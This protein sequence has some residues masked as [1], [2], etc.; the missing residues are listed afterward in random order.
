MVANVRTQEQITL[1]EE[2]LFLY[3]SDLPVNLDQYFSSHKTATETV[4]GIQDQIKLV[5]GLQNIFRNKNY[6]KPGK[7]ESELERITGDPDVAK[8]AMGQLAN[9]PTPV[10]R[11][12]FGLDKSITDAGVKQAFQYWVSGSSIVLDLNGDPAIDEKATQIAKA[13]NTQKE[14]RIFGEEHDPNMVEM[15]E[16]HAI[17][18]GRSVTPVSPT[19]DKPI[20]KSIVFN[21]QGFDAIVQALD[22]GFIL[23]NM[24]FGFF[25]PPIKTDFV[26]AAKQ[27]VGKV[28]SRKSKVQ[29][30]DETAVSES[31]VIALAKILPA[32]DAD[33]L[34]FRAWNG[35]EEGP[36][37]AVI[38][39]MADNGHVRI[40]DISGSKVSENTGKALGDMLAKNKG[41][42]KVVVD[43]CAFDVLAF[44]P[45]HA[46][47]EKNPNI[48]KFDITQ[49][50]S[51][52]AGSKEFG[53]IQ[54]MRT[55]KIKSDAAIETW[56]TKIERVLYP[57][58]SDANAAILKSAE[59]L[60]ETGSDVEPEGPAVSNILFQAESNLAQVRKNNLKIVR[61][62][63]SPAS[64]VSSLSGSSSMSASTASMSSVGT[65]SSPIS[66]ATT[67]S[68]LS[69]PS[70]P[71]RSRMVRAPSRESPPVSPAG[72]P[73][74]ARK[75]VV[76]PPQVVAPVP[77]GVD[78][79]APK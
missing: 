5:T 25:N 73:S 7:L 43:D 23:R 71:V 17:E 27:L 10:K 45:I 36:L 72:S 15:I 76:A 57:R 18:A 70:S 59:V 24:D 4:L 41:L 9:L 19:E 34:S 39:G 2:A 61:A 20:E 79:P 37:N 32:L 49:A 74:V 28:F 53:S 42:L 35:L 21:G 69:V 54:D 29:T 6:D 33:T 47:I 12:V 8:K 51:F 77:K 60:E 13:P 62:P 75:L 44:K 14:Q 56:H 3:V 30:K 52:V 48:R 11:E 1:A 40:L 31:S 46:G 58:D 66:P 64:S 78:G 67:S 38:A 22:K 65:P 63:A 68:L 50:S 16:R 55:Q 26:D